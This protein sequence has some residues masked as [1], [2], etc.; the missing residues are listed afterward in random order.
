[1]VKW[2]DTDIKNIEHSYTNSFKH[3]YIWWYKHNCL[4]FF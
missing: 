2:T 3:S 4:E 1:M